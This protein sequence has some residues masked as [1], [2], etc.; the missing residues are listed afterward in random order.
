[1][2]SGTAT[3]TAFIPAPAGQILTDKEL[4]AKREADDKARLEKIRQEAEK[5]RLEAEAKA[6]REAEEKARLEAERKAKEEKARL[7]AAAKAKR[8]AELEAKLAEGRKAREEAERKAQEATELRAKLEAQ[9]AAAKES[10]LKARAEAEQRAKAEK[11]LLDANTRNQKAEAEQ[12]PAVAAETAKA[13]D[14]TLAKAK[15]EEEN[16]DKAEYAYIMVKAPYSEIRTVPDLTAPA[17]FVG[18]KGD[19]FKYNGQETGWYHILTFS[20]ETRYIRKSA[21]QG[22]NIPPQP[23]KSEPTR[24]EI[25]DSIVDAKELQE[26]IYYQQ[27]IEEKYLLEVFHHYKISPAN[28]LTILTEAIDKSW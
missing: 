27:T 8:E 28:Y 25:Y 4:T 6:K 16:E 22:T 12:T 20:G 19:V 26:K 21:C 1:M 2:P 9:A 13:Q 10:E 11:N 17:L 23:P 24:K 5:A 3:V 14:E 15:L 18:L 7:E